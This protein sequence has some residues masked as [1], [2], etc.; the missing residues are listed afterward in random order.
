[1]EGVEPVI[2]VIPV[3]D[4]IIHPVMNRVSTNNNNNNNNVFLKYSINK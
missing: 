2:P 1:M 4:R 3:I